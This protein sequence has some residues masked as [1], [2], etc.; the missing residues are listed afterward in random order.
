MGFVLCP[1]AKRTKNI[2]KKQTQPTH[3]ETTK[4]QPLNNKIRFWGSRGEFAAQKC[5]NKGQHNL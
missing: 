1:H 5:K 2:P 3:K 4:K